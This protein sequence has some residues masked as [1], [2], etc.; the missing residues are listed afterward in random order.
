[1]ATWRDDLLRLG[2]KGMLLTRWVPCRPGNR[3]ELLRVI[4]TC[5]PVTG[6]D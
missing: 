5:G 2:G 1:V 6:G 3:R 4:R